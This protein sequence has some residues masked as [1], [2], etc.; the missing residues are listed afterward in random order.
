MALFRVNIKATTPGLASGVVAY[1]PNPGEIL[2]D[3]WL[4]VVTAWNASPACADVGTFVG[5][6][7][8]LYG[9]AAGGAPVDVT[10]PDVLAGGSAGDVLVGGTESDLAVRCAIAAASPAAALRMAPA[11]FTGP[12]PLLAVVS[13]DGTNGGGETPAAATAGSAPTIPAAI[14]ARV[15]ATN[16]PTIPAP[17]PAYVVASAPARVGEVGEGNETFQ[18]GPA[19][20]EVLYTVAAGT[21]AT[22]ADLE[23]AMLAATG[24]SGTFGDFVTLADD[25][26]TITATAKAGSGADNGW[27]FQSGTGGDFLHHSFNVA[28]AYPGFAAGDTLA[29][30]SAGGLVVTTGAN[31]TFK[32]GAPGG[33]VVYTVAAGTYTTLADVAN[34]M[35]GA[36][37][38]GHTGT[39]F[40]IV[41]VDVSGTK[42]EAVAVGSAYNGWDFLTGATDFLA[43][44]GFANAQ[45]LEGGVAAGLAVI[46]GTNDTFKFGAPGGE[47]VYT[48]AAG[49]YTTLAE[50]EAAMGAAVDPATDALSVLVTVT[51]NGTELVATA[52]TS[53]AGYNGWDFLAGA[54]DFLADS[55]FANA[56]ALEGGT[57]GGTPTGATEGEL[58]L[59]LDVETPYPAPAFASPAPNAPPFP[60]V[61]KV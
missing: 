60:Y 5:S 24:G 42:L 19:G 36:E 27:D 9:L 51:D 52:V 23:A 32:F 41:A 2:R 6:P 18:F 57:S 15:T 26:A 59:Y 11:R 49:L 8:G 20:S 43:A 40:D 50:V 31:D 33:E 55:G 56:Q 39:L 10:A 3:A 4:E 47:V 12:A 25:G 30:G 54:H 35:L 22:L 14:A 37:N 48:V 34:A 29:G 13:K 53:G 28:Y 21:Y 46:T 17:V 61:G 7:K 58:N 1:Q 16:P 38:P 45:S 44:S